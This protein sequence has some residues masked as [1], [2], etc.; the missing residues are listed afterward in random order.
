LQYWV[1]INII[2][3]S[4]IGL[5][6]CWSFGE[7]PGT[8]SNGQQYCFRTTIGRKSAVHR[9]SRDQPTDAAFR[10]GCR[11][12]FSGHSESIRINTR[13]SDGKTTRQRATAVNGLQFYWLM[14]G[15]KTSC[16]VLGNM[17]VKYLLLSKSLNAL[18]PAM[19]TRLGSEQY[20]KYQTNAVSHTLTHAGAGS[21]MIAGCVSETT[22]KQ[23]TRDLRNKWEDFRRKRYKIIR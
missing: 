6:N 17:I 18:L 19:V 5:L 15:R 4:E 20:R 2:W 9:D 10:I 14:G 11:K 21:L 23:N 16:R 8:L 22:K 12:P 13:P 7:P 3:W 1:N